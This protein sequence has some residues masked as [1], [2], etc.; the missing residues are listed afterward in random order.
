MNED[1]VVAKPLRHPWRWI[2]G[3]LVLAV[4][5]LFVYSL[6]SSPSVDHDI[7]MKYMF[8]PQI[9]NGAVLTVVITVV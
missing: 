8:N 7:I 3:V 2:S 5:G 9:L 4:L 1:D 6:W